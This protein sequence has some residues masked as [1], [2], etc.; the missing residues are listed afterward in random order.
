LEAFFAGYPRFKYDP[1]LPVSAQYRA[2]CHLYGFRR[3]VPGADAAYAGYQIAMTKAFESFYGTD[4]DDLGALQSLCRVLE[5]GPIP[6]T[7]WACQSA[8]R[9]VFVNIVDL[10]DWAKSASG[11]KRPPEKFNSL[12][13]LAEYTRCYERFFPQSKAKGT[14]LQFLLRQILCN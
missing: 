3:G 14:L 5:L 1:I 11:T 7:V 10:V 6:E 12:A 2:L 13:K 4:V 9:T 8:L